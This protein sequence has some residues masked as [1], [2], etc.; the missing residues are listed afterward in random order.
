MTDRNGKTVTTETARVI[1]L[2]AITAQPKDASGKLGDVLKFTVSA[3]GNGLTYQWQYSKDGGKTWLASS[4]R[5]TTATCT[6]SS[7]ARD[8]WLY[9]CRITDARGTMLTTDTA[10]V[11]VLR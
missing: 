9:R 10:R 8:G 5:T 1:V 6:L 7:A 11:S 2:P 3:T 4:S